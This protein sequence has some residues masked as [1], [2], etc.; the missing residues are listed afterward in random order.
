M[1]LVSFKA[2]GRTGFGVLA[3]EEIVD[4]ARRT[5]FSGLKA[6]I[7]A[8]GIELARS[9]ASKAAAD[10]ALGDVTLLAPVPDP[11]KILCVGLNYHD[12]VVET[13]RTLTDYPTLFTRF[14][15][16]L[17]GHESALV[18]PAISEKFDYEGELAIVIGKGGRHVA[19]E[20]AFDHI[21][22]YAP[23]NDGSV[24]DWQSHTS[25][26][27]PGKN[28]DATGG[29]GPALVTPDEV[30]DITA[31]TLTTRFN[32]EI[33]QSAA[34]SLLITPI[35]QLIAYISTFLTLEPG[36]VIV[37]GTPGG[38]GTK[39]NPPLYMNPGDVIEVEI[40][41]VGLLRNQVVAEG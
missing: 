40:S 39:R 11:G 4:L 3:G 19:A 8:N 41:G 17:V 14:A 6:L 38:V 25:Q 20:A 1:K 21:A 26:F 34:L 9:I 13:G 28:F 16:T 12:H 32:G 36:D 10:F 33:V 15:T 24:R 30:P 31:Q 22:G 18:K 5:G 23:F 35:P 37:T 27:T 29:F 7:A 2:E